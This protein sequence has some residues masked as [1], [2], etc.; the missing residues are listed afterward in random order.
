[1]DVLKASVGSQKFVDW[2][3]LVPLYFWSIAWHTS[4]CLLLNIFVDAWPQISAVHHL[5]GCLDVRLWRLSKFVSE[6]PRGHANVGFLWIHPATVN[7]SNRTS[8]AEWEECMLWSMTPFSWNIVMA[9]K[10][11]VRV[12]QLRNELSTE[13]VR[14]QQYCICLPR[15]LFARWIDNLVLIGAYFGQSISTRKTLVYNSVGC[16]LWGW[17]DTVRRPCVV[18]D[19]VL[20]K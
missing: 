13:I 20:R 17:S 4:A 11:R 5:Y 12:H 18:H 7:V 8:E 10:S 2:C 6:W 3:S 16:D 1:M 15:T 14:H 9:S 19:K